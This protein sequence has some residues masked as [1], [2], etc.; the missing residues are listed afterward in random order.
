MMWAFSFSR[1][2]DSTGKPPV[3]TF[4]DL[5]KNDRVEGPFRIKGYVKAIYKCPPCPPLATCK[6]CMADNVEVTNNLD[7]KNPALIKRL[8]IFTD[9]PEKFELKKKYFFVVKVKGPTPQGRAIENVDLISF[10]P[11]K[12]GKE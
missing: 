5:Q 9:K 6:P 4:E 3:L 8:R 7:E 1:E 11:V 2:Q 12:Q 10:D